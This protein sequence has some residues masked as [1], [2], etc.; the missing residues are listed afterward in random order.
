MYGVKKITVD[1]DDQMKR[2]L[3]RLAA[4]SRRSEA[5]LVRDAVAALI[6]RAPKPRPRGQLFRSSDDASSERVEELLSGFGER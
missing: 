4:S 2:D 5:K 3:E 1:L 6:G